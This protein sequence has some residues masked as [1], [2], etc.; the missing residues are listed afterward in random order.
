MD[1]INYAKEIFDSEIE[2]LKIVREKIDSEMIDVVNIIL[3]S[4]GKVVVT[5]IGKSGLIG[6]KIAATLAST[7]TYAVF[8][9]SAEGLHGDL[10]MISKDDVVLAISNSGNSDEIVAILPSIK[11]IGAKIVAMTGNRNSKLG[12]AADKILNIGV[13]REGCPLNLAPMS[14]T[15]STLVMGDALAAILIKMRDFK[16]EN[17]ALYHPGGS[18]GKRLLMR[19][20]DVMHK[21]DKIPFCD[22]ESSIDNVILVM[23]EKRLGAVCVMNGDLM[24]G[25]ITEG[26]IRRALKRKEEF[27]NLK[28]KDIMTR[29]FTRVSEDSMA[30]DALELMENRE[31][32]ISVLPVFKDV[33]LVGI[34]RVHDL[35]NVV[36][37]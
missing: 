33:K 5:G 25:I 29:N 22:K 17:F 24:V 1:V 11:K 34:V 16:P 12:R 36:G 14:S 8:M 19:V 32:Q 20:S 30:I 35:L 21:D 6:K 37:R 10:G 3:E 18:L 4:K 27:F 31:S 15:T 9:N 28:A 23:T 13:K 2:E 7:G 26:D